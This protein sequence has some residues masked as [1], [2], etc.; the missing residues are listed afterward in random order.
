[1]SGLWSLNYIILG[2]TGKGSRLHFPNCN[3]SIDGRKGV[4][5]K[6]CERRANATCEF[7]RRKLVFDERYGQALKS[8]YS[9]SYSGFRTIRKRGNLNYGKQQQ[10]VTFPYCRMTLGVWSI[11]RDKVCS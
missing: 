5:S 6:T 3:A 4:T 7:D 1:M 2:V 11:A 9:M 10:N 8:L